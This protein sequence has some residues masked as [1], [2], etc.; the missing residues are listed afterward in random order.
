[1]YGEMR[2]Y[3]RVGS[4]PYQQLADANRFVACQTEQLLRASLRQKATIS[5]AHGLAHDRF[6]NE[7]LSGPFVLD[8]NNRLALA[9]SEHGVRK[10]EAGA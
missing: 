7:F 9:V 1:M 3:L 4:A 10:E 8:V 5:V 6:P 2:R